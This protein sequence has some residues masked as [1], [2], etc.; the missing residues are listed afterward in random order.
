MAPAKIFSSPTTQTGTGAST[1]SSISLVTLNS[2]TRG[3]ATAW[4]P[5]K[6]IATAISPGTSTVAKEAPGPAAEALA[7]LREDVREDEDEQEW[8]RDRP[9]QELADVETQDADV[10]G[11]QRAERL[12]ICP[13][14]RYSRPVRLRKT[15]SRLGGRLEASRTASPSSPAACT[16]WTSTPSERSACTRTTW[17]SRSTERTPSSR[18]ARSASRAGSPSIVS[19]ISV[20]APCLR[21]SS[22]GVSIASALPWSM[23]AILSQRTSASSM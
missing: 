22:A 12:Q 15:V 3:G 23:I 20:S 21:F 1:R 11:Q 6:L 2:C 7:D 14:S 10:A 5:W 13:H 9:D 18:S 4:I 19:V 16:S 17:P 8:L